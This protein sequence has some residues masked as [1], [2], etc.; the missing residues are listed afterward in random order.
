MLLRH[1]RQRAALGCELAGLQR[2]PRDEAD[3]LALTLD[4][5]ALPLAVGEVVSVL[6]GDHRKDAPRPLNLLDGRFRQTGVADLPLALKL[7]D[8]VEL[9]VLRD[10]R[11]DAMQLPQ[12]NALQAQAPQT[13]FQFLAQPL[14][15]SV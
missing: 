9:L 15:A 8:G 13:S 3:G 6:H 14:R 1:F 11:I 7:A 10:L 5:H 2:E 4:E 12:V